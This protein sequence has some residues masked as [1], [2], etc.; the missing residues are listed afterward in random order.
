[1][2]GANRRKMAYSKHPEELQYE[3]LCLVMH[4]FKC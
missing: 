1:M 2:L 4:R 3:E